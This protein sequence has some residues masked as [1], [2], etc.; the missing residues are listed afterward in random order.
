M[1]STITFSP[2]AQGWTSFWDYNP[3]WMLG[4]NSSF[5]TWKQGQLYKHDSNNTRNNFYGVGYSSSITTVFNAEPTQ[6]KVF[7]TLEL[8]STHPWNATLN[9]DLS[10][11]YNDA[12][13]FLEKEAGWFSYI[14]SVA[15]T[16]DSH[17]LY[18][19][20]LG[21]VLGIT[22]PNT[23]ELASVDS[24]I[25]AGDLLYVYN[26]NINTLT[27]IGTVTSNTDTSVTFTLVSSPSVGDYIV[28]IKNNLAESF[29]LRGY[30]MQVELS[31]FEQSPVELF[32]ITSS[33]FKSS[34]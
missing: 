12:S 1:P 33:V 22:P 13:Y 3:D 2:S 25:S 19:Q 30:Y 31:I 32:E 7:K 5:Y 4:L 16:N 8:D 15:G 9:T 27:L 28:Y 26:T 17:E 11:G 14:R 10:N 6:N 24:N 20:G 23:I 34:P 29:G 21:Q 18:T